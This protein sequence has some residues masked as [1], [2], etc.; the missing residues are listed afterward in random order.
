M[1]VTLQILIF[2]AIFLLM[3][4]GLS[5]VPWIDIFDIDTFNKEKQEQ[6]SELVLKM[7]RQDKKEIKKE[8]AVAIINDI[9]SLLC[10]ANGIDTADITLHLFEDEIINAFALPGG[11]IVVNTGLIN[12]CDNPDMLAGVMAHEIAHIELQHVSR[13]L[14]REIGLSSLMVLTGGADNLVLLQEVLYTLSSRG[15]DRSMEAEAD[16]HAVLYLQAANIDPKQLA[17]FLNK[18]SRK[19]EELP[20]VLRWLSTHPGADERVKEILNTSGSNKGYQ[21][22]VTDSTWQHFRNMTVEDK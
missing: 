15:F 10:A 8:D 4:F 12:L 2:A 20:D 7:H 21:Q 14:A 6:L 1:K 22:V 16:A 9:K 11:H 13:K 17:H 19:D 3:W 5:K 18:L